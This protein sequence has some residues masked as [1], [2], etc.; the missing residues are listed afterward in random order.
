MSNPEN[1]QI[2]QPYGIWP[3]VTGILLAFV[4]VLILFAGAGGI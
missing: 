1:K 2:Y 3:W 4:L